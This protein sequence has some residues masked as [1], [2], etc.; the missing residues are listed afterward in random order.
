MLKLHHPLSVCMRKSNLSKLLKITQFHWHSLHCYTY[1]VLLRFSFLLFII[2]AHFLCQ[3]QKKSRLDFRCCTLRYSRESMN[4]LFARWQSIRLT[5]SCLKRTYIDII[6][7]NI[8]HGVPKTLEAMVRQIGHLKYFIF[9]KKRKKK[10]KEEK[11]KGNET[12]TKISFW[13]FHSLI[14]EGKL[15]ASGYLIRL[16]SIAA[17]EEM[18]QRKQT[19]WR[20]TSLLASNDAWLWD[21]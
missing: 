14:K 15:F 10:R 9:T 5:C 19:Y 3:S 7:L 12:A 18:F 4:F 21:W 6:R 16:C 8:C 17:A 20:D 11:I 1:I 13:L 2:S